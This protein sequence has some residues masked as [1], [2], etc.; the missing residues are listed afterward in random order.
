MGEAN[1][2]QPVYQKITV[3]NIGALGFLESEYTCFELKREKRKT[4]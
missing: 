4:E 1:L 2:I 3:E